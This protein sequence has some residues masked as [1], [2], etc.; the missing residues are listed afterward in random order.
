MEVTDHPDPSI[1]RTTDPDA[2][3]AAPSPLD[4]TGNSAS[5]QTGVPC[6]LPRNCAR[7]PGPP[8]YAGPRY[9]MSTT[10]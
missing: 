10:R 4:Q 6:G 5:P 2:A 1:H 7:P 3:P 8:I 9:G